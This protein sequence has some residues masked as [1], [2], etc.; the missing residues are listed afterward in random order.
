MKTSSW[1]KLIGILCI[2]FGAL[3]LIDN[4]S[5][6][7]VPQWVKDTWPEI[8]PDRIKWMEMLS[9]IGIIVNTI[10]LMSGVF[11]MLKKPFSLNLMYS[12]LIISILYIVIPSFIVKPNADIIFVLIGPI[13]DLALLIGVYRIRKYYYESPNEIV[14]PL[15]DIILAL[16]LLKLLTILGILFIF[17]PI[18]IQGLWIY[19]SQSGTTPSQSIAIFN[20]YFPDFLQGSMGYL[21][22]IFCLMAII[23]SIICLNSS[24]SKLYETLHKIILSVSTLFLLLNLFQMM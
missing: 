15:G 18:L 5:S 19:A 10:Y 6:F 9:Y 1:I 22:L 4:I 7:F 12:A 3:G 11:F 21:S 23:I 20:S 14:K 8:S 24:M 2:V 16:P 13:I 17:I